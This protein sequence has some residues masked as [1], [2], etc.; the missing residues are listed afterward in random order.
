MGKKHEKKERRWRKIK[1]Y[2][3]N[4]K[5]DFRSFKNVEKEK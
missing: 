2:E 1:E 3:D 4:V 5:G